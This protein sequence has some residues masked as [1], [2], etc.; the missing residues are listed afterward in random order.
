[1]K[2]PLKPKK[3][4]TMG[5][6]WATEKT[7]VFW[8]QWSNENNLGTCTIWSK[9]LFPIRITLVDNDRIK[10]NQGSSVWDT[11]RQHF[12]W[13]LHSV[14][15]LGWALK[16]G[17]NQDQEAQLTS[18][19]SDWRRSNY[20]TWEKS[21]W[22]EF[23]KWYEIATRQKKGFVMAKSAYLLS[24]VHSNP[25]KVQLLTKCWSWCP[26]AILNII[27]SIM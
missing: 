11:W 3:S 19:N 25:P 15:A 14:P 10:I 7:N 1:M 5:R 20:H 2:F 17:H 4:I 23:W 26:A 8:D 18:K 22:R 24:T 13:S 16:S 6:R 21:M 27:G 12:G 9:K